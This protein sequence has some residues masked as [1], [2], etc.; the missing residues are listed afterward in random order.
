MSKDKEKNQLK[1][2]ISSDNACEICDAWFANKTRL[3]SHIASVH[4]GKKPHKCE[5]CDVGFFQKGTQFF[6]YYGIPGI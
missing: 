2:N 6:I 5:I 1:K 4:E 3:K